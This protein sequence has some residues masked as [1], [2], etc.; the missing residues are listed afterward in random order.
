MQLLPMDHGVSTS[1]Q[2]LLFLIWSK[3]S[4]ESRAVLEIRQD[5]SGEALPRTGRKKI[6]FTDL[7]GA[8]LF[9]YPGLLLASSYFIFSLCS[10]APY[11]IF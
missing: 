2:L 11:N 6:D 9:L 5:A 4:L 8:N 3:S 7:H 1:D 10:A